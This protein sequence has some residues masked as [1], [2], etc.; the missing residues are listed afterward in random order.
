M[1]GADSTFVLSVAGAWLDGQIET[2]LEMLARDRGR[3][4][5][6]LVKHLRSRLDAQVEA[7]LATGALDPA[8]DHRPRLRWFLADRGLLPDAPPDEPARP[9]PARWAEVLDAPAPEIPQVASC[10]FCG[11]RRSCTGAGCG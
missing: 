8:D 7:L 3:R 10:P 4:P 6:E 11:H 9:A 5:P 2:P 1:P